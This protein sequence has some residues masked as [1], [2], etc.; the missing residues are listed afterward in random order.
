ML[1]FS[2]FLVFTVNLRKILLAQFGTS[3][4]EGHLC[5]WWCNSAR[6]GTFS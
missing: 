1:K 3:C 5:G 4:R 6:Y 2:C